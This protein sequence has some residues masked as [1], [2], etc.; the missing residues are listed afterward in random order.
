MEK[1][2]ADPEFIHQH[3]FEPLTIDRTSVNK[4]M[5]SYYLQMNDGVT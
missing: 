1:E 5:I 2:R 4:P 3:S